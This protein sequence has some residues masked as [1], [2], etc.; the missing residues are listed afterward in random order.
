MENLPPPKKE[1]IPLL[2]DVQEEDEWAFKSHFEVAVEEEIVK[3]SED[4]DNLPMMGA[5]K[6]ENVHHLFIDPLAE[7]MEALIFSNTPAL[8][9]NMGQIN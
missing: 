3:A 7:Y 6:E 1:E 9:F 2:F 5:L 4:E 8:I